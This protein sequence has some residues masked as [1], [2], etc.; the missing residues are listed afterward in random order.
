MNNYTHSL[1]LVTT[2]VA[3]IR[4]ILKRMRSYTN[5]IIT[6]A[7]LCF[8]DSNMLGGTSNLRSLM[9][10]SSDYLAARIRHIYNYQLFRE[11]LCY[12]C[13]E[14]LVYSKITKF[15]LLFYI[16]RNWYLEKL[17]NQPS[18]MLLINSVP[19]CYILLQL[20]LKVHLFCSSLFSDSYLCVFDSCLCFLMT[21]EVG[22]SF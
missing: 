8:Y 17:H 16:E 12:H 20:I 10:F 11:L 13:R 5:A 7:I 1:C 21:W 19:G 2:S 15:H 4:S 22:W 3:I 9:C 14:L 6:P 18:K